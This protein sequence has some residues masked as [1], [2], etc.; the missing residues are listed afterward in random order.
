M[1]KLRIM[2]ALAL[3]MALVA[4]APNA[5]AQTLSKCS[6]AKKQCVA[7]KVAGLLKCHQKAEKTGTFVSAVCL[8][9]VRDKFDGGSNPAKGCFAKLEAK[10]L[11][12]VSVGDAALVEGMADTFVNA[13]ICQLDPPA[14]TCPVPTASPT[15]P[16]PMVTP[17]PSCVP[18]G[19]EV[20][21]GID[22]D[23]NGV[24]DDGL[25]SSTC[26]VGLCQRTVDNC[27]AGV[28]QSCVPGSPSTEVCD[29]GDNDCNGMTDEGLGVIS[30]GTGQCANT[31]QSCVMGNP[32]VCTPLSPST[33]VCDGVDNNCNGVTDDGTAV[34]SCPMRANATSTCNAGNCGFVCSAGFQDCDG[35]P[36]NGCEVNLATDTNHCGVC[37]NLCGDGNECTFDNCG[38]GTCQ[39]PGKP[40]G[41][42]CG[43]GMMC[44]ASVCQ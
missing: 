34:S 12:C 32:Q 35:S 33:E 24:T 21:D 39:Y 9:K 10:F 3:A 18:T 28:P 43:V 36:A 42:P 31:V 41:S 11:D 14:G 44:T 22:N 2:L 30:C 4:L 27:I 23:C 19:P 29:G 7:K 5:E 20:C 6:A 15:C 25:G 17:T 37:G 8:Q 26:G 16:G 38:A 40:N 13:I 1:Q